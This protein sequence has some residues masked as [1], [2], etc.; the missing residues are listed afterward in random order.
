LINRFLTFDSVMIIVA[1]AT[2]LAW[3]GVCI[4]AQPTAGTTAKRGAFWMLLALLGPIILLIQIGNAEGTEPTG[5]ALRGSQA[6]SFAT[7]GLALL[8][9][10]D[11]IRSRNRLS[12]LSNA[13][14]V[15]YVL[16]V[17]TGFTGFVVGVPR[18]YW[19]TPMLLLPALL[20]QGFSLQELL[21]VVRWLMRTVMVC[22]LVGIVLV[23][24]KV[25]AVALA[26][27]DSRSTFGLD[28]LQGITSHPNTLG[29]FA[30]V[31]I[32]LE[33]DRR[34]W[35]WAAV[36]A[37]TLVLTQSHTS[38]FAVGFAI[39]LVSPFAMRSVK[40]A[41]VVGVPGLILVAMFS[42]A[43][44]ASLWAEIFPTDGRGDALTG[45]TEIWAAALKGFEQFPL[46]GYGPSLL[47]D[48]YRARYLP[49]FDAAAQAH[50]Q[51]V[52]TLGE[53]GL[54]G[55]AVLMVVLV[56]MVKEGRKVR[57]VSSVPLALVILVLARCVTETPLR[58]TGVGSFLLLVTFGSLAAAGRERRVVAVSERTQ[59]GQRVAL[60]SSQQAEVGTRR[61]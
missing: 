17:L 26:E 7:L 54:V 38:W 39:V 14:M 1:A 24:N 20:Y 44:V 31:A 27:Y 11:A 52:Q 35:W 42:P 8:L 9:I 12:P 15:M 22:S 33:V 16:G 28:R 49:G 30:A 13:V 5:L 59:V 4:A 48:A 23:P 29:A 6:V 45:R 3:A 19:L 32:I 36:A 34:N 25:L 50:N 21:R 47:D 46:L 57:P 37:V 43:R 61:Q 60:A 55:L 2:V 40:T 41:A 10:V 56:L 58:P 53:A 51:F 18:P